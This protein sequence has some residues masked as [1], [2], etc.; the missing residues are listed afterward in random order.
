MTY[1]K[2]EILQAAEK[3]KEQ[4]SKTEEVK[5]YKLAEEKID[6]NQKVTDKVA[7]IKKLQKESVNLEHYQKYKAMKLTEN[8]IDQ[9]QKEI[10]Q[11]PIVSEFKSAQIDA[12]ELL[13][14]VTKEI[15]HTVSK[16]TES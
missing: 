1:S 13:Q 3:L 5:F 9:L 4:I 10:D 15:S 6:A 7:Q 12:N 16:F 2:E 14:S 11:L 8:K